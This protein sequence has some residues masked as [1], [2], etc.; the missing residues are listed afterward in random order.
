MHIMMLCVK[1][2]YEGLIEREKEHTGERVSVLERSKV[3]GYEEYF[4][5][6]GR[7]MGAKRLN[8]AAA[9]KANQEIHDLR[10]THH[11]MLFPPL[12]TT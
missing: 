7:M 8:K 12:T 10:M 3:E 2:E 9:E 6:K 5:K 1:G 4:V 11:D